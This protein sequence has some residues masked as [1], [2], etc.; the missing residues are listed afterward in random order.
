MALGLT[1]PLTEMSPRNLPR[2]LRAAGAQDSRFANVGEVAS[3]TDIG[4][5]AV[6]QPSGIVSPYR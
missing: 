2:D 3:L 6:S 1:R 5:P 4:D